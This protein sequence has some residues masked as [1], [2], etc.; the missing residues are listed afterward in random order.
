M[1][2]TEQLKADILHHA[3]STFP[4]E[5]CGVIVSGQYYP[6]ENIS[7]EPL[8]A[9][10]INP[11]DSDLAEEKG[12]LEAYVHS[13]PNASHHASDY[14]K[15]QI[16]KFKRP[17]VICS[18]PDVGFS[19]NEPCGYRPP[20]VGRSFYHGW[21]DCYTLIK[22]FYARE[23]E[24]EIP[25]FE[26]QDRW[27]ED[28]QSESLY[29]ENYEKAGFRQVNNLQYGDV[30][31]FSIR[32]KHANHAAIYLEDKDQLKSEE[33]SKCIGSQL[34]LHHMYDSLSKRDIYSKYWMDRTVLYLRH[35]SMINA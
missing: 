22:D 5:C 1:E 24:I 10:K 17:W 11:K 20:L 16:E 35:G 29:I 13:H 3:R 8:K 19:I 6:C 28:S 23:L 33:S 18:L 4:E 12:Q 30:I 2:L 34:I 25:N 27:W 26:R 15:M 31:L 14:D 32:S 21:Q 7:P 9:F